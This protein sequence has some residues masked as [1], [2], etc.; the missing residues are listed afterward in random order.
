MYGASG[1]F[2]PSGLQLKSIPPHMPHLGVQTDPV[3]ANKSYS[4]AEYT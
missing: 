4:M 1:V 2:S 3:A